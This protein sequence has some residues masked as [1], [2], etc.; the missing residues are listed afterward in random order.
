MSLEQKRNQVFKNVKLPQGYASN[1]GRCEQVGERKIAGYKSHDAHFMMNYLLP[2]A[3][4][5]TLPKDV[6]TP[7]TRLCAF[8]KSI[9]SETF[10]PQHLEKNA[11]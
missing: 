2:V 11:I 6:A 4:K 5:T 10:N 8:F 3:V 9:W 7:L 1:I